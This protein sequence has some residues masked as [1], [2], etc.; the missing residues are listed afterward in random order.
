VNPAEVAKQVKAAE[1]ETARLRE[2]VAL[3]RELV[4]VRE[5]IAEVA[6]ELAELRDA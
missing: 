6:A 5:R 1:A 3:T 4:Q 2:Q